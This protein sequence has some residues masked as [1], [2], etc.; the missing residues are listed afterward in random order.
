MMMFAHISV[1]L[2]VGTR[3]DSFVIDGYVEVDQLSGLHDHLIWFI[4]TGFLL[5]GPKTAS[6]V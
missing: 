2:S 6:V 5:V 4:S 3:I 1:S